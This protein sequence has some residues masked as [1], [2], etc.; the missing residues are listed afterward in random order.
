MKTSRFLHWR[1]LVTVA[2]IAAAYPAHAADAAHPTV[3]DL[4][5]S[6]G[7]SSCPPANANLLAIAGRADVLALSWEV[8]YWDYLGWADTFGDHRYTERQWDYARGLHNDDVFTPQ[9]VINGRT[10]L[11]GDHADELDAAIGRA[12]RGAGGPTL[13]LADDHVS[14][15]AGAAAGDI[16][17]V[18]YDPRLIQVPIHRG[19]NGGRTLP[20]RNVVRELRRLGAWN[21][22]PQTYAL[23]AAT[24][25][26][27]KTAILVQS[28]AGG[29]ILAAIHS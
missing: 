14:V 7:C 23:P 6:Q 27:L 11:V 4:C 13:Q 19:E 15:G 17:M 18:R 26:G 24:H 21:G 28:R 9:I 5:Q 29:P 3:V 16:V 12:D 25:E 22:S 10:D 1:P 20:H 2:L 8:T